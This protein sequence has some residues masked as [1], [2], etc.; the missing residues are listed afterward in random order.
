[1]AAG[2]PAGW[3]SIPNVVKDPDFVTLMR[4]EADGSAVW[5]AWLLGVDLGSNPIPKGSA[6]LELNIALVQNEAEDNAGWARWA[7]GTQP[8]NTGNLQLD[9]AAAITASFILT[10]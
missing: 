5:A 7:P 10:I 4:A 3:F 9:M 1:M 6:N 8:E 2:I